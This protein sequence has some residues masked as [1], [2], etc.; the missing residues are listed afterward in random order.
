MTVAALAGAAEMSPAPADDH[1]A[2]LVG[3]TRV[4]GTPGSPKS[5]HALGPI[6]LDLRRGEFFSVVGPSGC[7]KSTLLDVLAGLSRAPTTIIPTSNGPS[8]PT[9]GA[10]NPLGTGGGVL[11]QLQRGAPEAPVAPGGSAPAAPAPA[12]SA[13]APAAPSGPEVPRSQ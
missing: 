7:G 5:V 3:V 6:D 13:P 12:P 8:A 10:P 9:P 4:F 1:H 11:D 2:R